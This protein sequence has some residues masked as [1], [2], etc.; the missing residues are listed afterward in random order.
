MEPRGLLASWDAARGHLTLNGA[1]KVAFPNRRT[2][3]AMMGL[4]ERFLADGQV[5]RQMRF[6]S[7]GRC[8]A[9]LE[10]AR[11]GSRVGF[12]LNLPQDQTERLLRARVTEL[13][14]VVE[15]R[16]ELTGLAAGG[17]AVTAAV[18][19]PG[20]QAETITEGSITATLACDPDGAGKRM[21]DFVSQLG[22][23]GWAG[24]SS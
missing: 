24:T 19:G 23:T 15:N 21:A 7:E 18:R 17:D 8:L 20:G 10:F 3:A 6:Y 13:G 11:C 16:T 1:A 4:A 22:G 2:L 14:G 5:V 12:M 9:R